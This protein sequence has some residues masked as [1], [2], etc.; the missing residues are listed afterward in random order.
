MLYAPLVG[1]GDNLLATRTSREPASL[2]ISCLDALVR[3]NG[4]PCVHIAIVVA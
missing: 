3:A 1:G 2:H 4:S